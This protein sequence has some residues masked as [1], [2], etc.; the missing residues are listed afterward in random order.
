MDPTATIALYAAS[1][2]LVDGALTYDD[3]DV[4][5]TPSASLLPNT[6]YQAVLDWCGGSDVWSF[7][8]TDVGSWTGDPT[9]MVYRL[10]LADADWVEPEAAG[11]LIASAISNSLLLKVLAFDGEMEL[12]LAW[13]DKSGLHQDLCLATADETVADLSTLPGFGLGPSDG[14][15]V[16]A[17]ESLVLRDRWLSARFADDLGSLED[18]RFGGT[19]DFRD[20]ADFFSE[21]VGTEDADAICDLFASVGATCGACADGASYCADF[22]AEEV[23]AEAVSTKVEERTEEEI[24][25][26]PRCR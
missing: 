21:A 15:L 22:R 13:T 14:T 17:G 16:V 6:G 4:V 20:W 12:R 24:S 7:V 2:D 5:F 9:G 10:D 26:D 23:G 3:R 8:T 19:V 25:L 1:G 11:T 18:T